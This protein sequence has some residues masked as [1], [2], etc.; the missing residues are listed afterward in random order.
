[1][2]IITIHDDIGFNAQAECGYR[3]LDSTHED[4]RVHTHTFYEIF[5][6]TSGAASHW[7]N[8]QEQLL[9][10]GTL[11][12]IRD[13]DV[14]AFRKTNSR[15]NWINVNF[16]KNTL[17]TLFLYLDNPNVS[18]K[19]LTAKFPPCIQLS[20]EQQYALTE[21]FSKLNAIYW[22]NHYSLKLETRRQLMEIFSQYFFANAYNDDLV[23][24]SPAWFTSLCK[25]MKEH[26]NFSRGSERMY[27]L[28]P[29]SKSHLV[30]CMKKYLHTTVSEF[31]NEQRMTYAV[32]L[33]LNSK[34]SIIDI[35][36]ECGYFNLNYFY[37][38]F[39][40]YYGKA[41]KEF[42]LTYSKK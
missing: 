36:F 4:N 25:E 6:I 11:M 9:P 37:R 32:N 5:L 16:S 24:D 8:G 33:L 38:L 22:Q 13:K 14:H 29:K 26:K 30:R 41:P 15:F 1:M 42:R 3:Y 35:S 19:L 34:M 18:N 23:S 20:R 7:V 40:K 17:N 12:F 28:C 21:N 10:E 2:D 39:R 31:I 27:E